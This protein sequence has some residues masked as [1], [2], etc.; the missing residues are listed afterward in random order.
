MVAK[1]LQRDVKVIRKLINITIS[2]VQQP[3]RSGKRNK[4]EKEHKLNLNINFIKKYTMKKQP[5][6]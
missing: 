5:P 1:I 6:S 3:N 4:N 2:L